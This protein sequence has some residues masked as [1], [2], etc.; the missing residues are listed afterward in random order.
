MK[1]KTTIL[2]VLALSIITLSCSS[3]DNA[4]QLFIKASAN[5]TNVKT[6]AAQ[7]NIELSK[8]KINIREIELEYDDDIEDNNNDV[9]PEHLYEDVEFDGPFELDLLSGATQINIAATEVPIDTFEEIEFDMSRSIDAASDLFGKSILIE[10][11]IDGTPFV[12]WHDSDEEFEVDY[13]NA[14]NDI[15]MTGSNA[16]IVINFD[17][18]IIFGAASGIDF[19]TAMDGNGDGVIEIHP[20]D[21]DGNSGLAD[22][23]IEL[24]HEGAD[25][26][27]D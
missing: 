23:I 6:K 9:T 26:L 19:S 13:E 2:I 15:V 25:L 20:G 3:E 7:A 5:Y 21:D 18:N 4:G 8:F 14:A 24:L 10:G 16:S 11:T 1:F 22:S 27:D 12:F 17:L